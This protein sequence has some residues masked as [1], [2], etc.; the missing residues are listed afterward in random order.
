MNVCQMYSNCH[1]CRV[2][3]ALTLERHWRFRSFG[4]K[5]GGGVWFEDFG[6]K[7]GSQMVDH[8]KMRGYVNF[9]LKL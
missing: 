7:G 2:I 9:E 5:G 3:D 8:Y 6:D 4:L 1:L